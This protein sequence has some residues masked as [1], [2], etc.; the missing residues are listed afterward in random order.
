MPELLELMPDF[1]VPYSLKGRGLPESIYAPA[2]VLIC[3]S[4]IREAILPL[5]SSFSQRFHRTVY[6]LGLLRDVCL[7][8]ARDLAG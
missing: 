2:F 1:A 4:P 5:P 8:Q 7:S 3:E 6:C